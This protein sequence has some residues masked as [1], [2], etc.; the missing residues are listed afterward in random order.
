M[1]LNKI[2]GVAAL[3]LVAIP[4]SLGITDVT[5]AAPTGT[6]FE[7]RKQVNDPTG[8]PFATFAVLPNGSSTLGALLNWRN[9]EFSGAGYTPER[10][11]YEVTNRLNIAVNNVGGKLSSLWLTFGRMNGYTVLCYVNKPSFG[12]NS[13]N[14]LW[15]LNGQ[16]AAKPDEVIA[17]LLNFVETKG[18]SG[19]PIQESGGQSYVNLGDLVDTAMNAGM[20]NNGTTPSS[21][22][23]IKPRQDSP[24]NKPS[25]EP[26]AVDDSGI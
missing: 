8:S 23:S 5:L 17:R 21:K 2:I 19:V 6:S 24:A 4:V 16:N 18:T 25:V 12:C 14:V 13:S 20:T 11:C 10:R 15:T 9:E 22:P 26:S 3:S 1:I 7:C